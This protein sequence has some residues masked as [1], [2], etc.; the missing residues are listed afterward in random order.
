MNK[1]TILDLLKQDGIQPKYVATTNGG[2]YASSCP[3]CGGNDRFRSWPNQGKGGRFWCRQCNSSGGLIQ[4]LG[5]FKNLDF[6]RSCSFLGIDNTASDFDKLVT[7][8]RTEQIKQSEKI[9]P[10]PELWQRKAISFIEYAQREL[11]ARQNN[12]IRGWLNERGL[13][14]F[15][16][17]I[18]RLGWNPDGLFFDREEWGLPEKLKDTGNPVKFWIPAGLV[19]PCFR[20]RTLY[21]ISVR[22]SDPYNFDLPPKE[23][24]RYF[25]LAGSS[26]KPPQI[27]GQEPSCLIVVESDL[28]AMLINQEAGKLI[29]VISMGSATNR[30]DKETLKLISKARLILIA[31]DRDEAGINSAWNWWLE[32]FPNARRWPSIK[33]KD[34]GEDFRAGVDLRKWVMAGLP[35]PEKKAQ[36][37]LKIIERPKITIESLLM[38]K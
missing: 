10:P 17:K 22:R 11:S 12:K 26:S 27:L 9:L 28:D 7:T 30:P 14:K 29:T 15:T 2:E 32:N 33:G 35:D 24:Q 23:D 6:K 3:G 13:N 1:V 8:G 37:I 31:L 38:E 5:K 18:N 19:I 36:N 20:K 34:P 25:L 16:T 4:Y 21:R